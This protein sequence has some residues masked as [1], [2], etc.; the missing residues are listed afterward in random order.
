MLTDEQIYDALIH[1]GPRQSP[2]HETITFELTLI[3][4]FWDRPPYVEVW[5]DN[6][7]KYGSDLV[8]GKNKIIVDHTFKFNSDHV[9]KLVRS[10]KSDDQVKIVNGLVEKD[11]LVKLEKVVVDGVNI[12]NIMLSQSYTESQ[13]PEPWATKQKLQ[14]IKLEKLIIGNT[15]FGHNATWYLKFTSPFYK[16]IMTWMR[17]EE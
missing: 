17:G 7:L 13:Y 16:F 4:N 6:E 15:H 5:V 9:L 10:G 3:T 12:Q 11:Q 1:E 8:Q 2:T 14:G